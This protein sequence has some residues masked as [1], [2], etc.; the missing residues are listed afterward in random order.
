VLEETVC[1]RFQIA[2]LVI[3]IAACLVQ[4]GYAQPDLPTAER[5]RI[6]A[7]PLLGQVGNEKKGT[8]LLDLVRSGGIVGVCILVL[9]VI[10]FAFAIEQLI[11][12]R[13]SRLMPR[14]QLEFFEQAIARGDVPG[15]LEYCQSTKPN[16]LIN[17]IQAGLERYQASEFGFAEYR[18]AVE[19]AGEYVTG[20]LYRKTEILSLIAAIA[21]MLG[22]L[23]TVL[24]MIEAFNTIAQKGDGI[25]RPDEL[26]G[27]IGQALVTTLLGLIVAI[28]TLIA[29]SYFRNQID[30]IV[31][32]TGMQVERVLLPLSR[33]KK[34]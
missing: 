6:S 34:P 16:L 13:R 4:P 20:K 7:P 21:P 23:G 31:A 14:K 22:L 24:G 2:T 3:F 12:L 15:A 8:T 27:G 9:S 33:H 32:E 17:V 26:A 19:E 1:W 11:S 30:A 28:P 10:A 18:T 29:Y 5:D 25:A